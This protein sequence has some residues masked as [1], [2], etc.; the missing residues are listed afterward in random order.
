MGIFSKTFI[1]SVLFAM[2]VSIAQAAI[3]LVTAKDASTLYAEKKAIIVDVRE[4]DEWKDEHIAGALHIPLKQLN[5]RVSELQPYK[6][7]TIIT[8]CKS[9]GRSA[10][11]LEL[12][13]AAGF[14]KV[15]SMDGGIKTWDQQGLATTK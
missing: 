6:D 10:K 13:K 4:D 15:Y 8:Q 11:A 1:L 14:T 9:G 3:E 5:D 7:T 12:L 2:S